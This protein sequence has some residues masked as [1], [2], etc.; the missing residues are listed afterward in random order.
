MK[1]NVDNLNTVID[2]FKGTQW[3]NVGK[4][5]LGAVAAY[6]GAKTAINAAY[7]C[8]VNE[9]T[10]KTLKYVVDHKDDEMFEIKP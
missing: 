6:V 9:A 5:V 3:K 7:D 8:G 10:Q 4:F 2:K 1:V